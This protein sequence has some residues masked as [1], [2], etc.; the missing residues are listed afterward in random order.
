VRA[1]AV[2]SVRWLMAVLEDALLEGVIE[3]I[4]RPDYRAFEA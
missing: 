4:T 2:V 3:R 1:V